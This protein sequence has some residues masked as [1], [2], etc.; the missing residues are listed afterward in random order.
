MES[1]RCKSIVVTELNK[2]GLQF[3]SVELGEVEITEPISKEKL[4]LFDEVLR[5][6]GLELMETKKGK[7]VEKIRTAIYELIYES[8]NITKPNF[9]DYISKKVN[10]DYTYLST[11]FSREQG[12][13]IEKY[14]IAQRIDRV[15]ELL[16]Y[17]DMIISHIAFLMKY[18][19]VAHLSNQFKK[20]TG[21]TPSFYKQLRSDS[22]QKPKKM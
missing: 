19:S 3:R 12:I 13:T 10:R 7:M 11:L 15:K 4:Q 5:K 20:V 6:V 8:D 17:N 21:L 2:L 14:I 22:R 9:S 1:D 16:I 18:S